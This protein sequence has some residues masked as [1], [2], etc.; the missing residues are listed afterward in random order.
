[1]PRMLDAPHPP[2]WSVASWCI[3][4]ATL[5]VVPVTV[6]AVLFVGRSPLSASF[7]FVPKVAVASLLLSAS[8]S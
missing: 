2:T 5:A 8:A 3:L 6:G 1:M 4:L 7:Y